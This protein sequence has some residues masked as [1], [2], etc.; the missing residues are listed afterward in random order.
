ML[1]QQYARSPQVSVS[2]DAIDA[3]G[4]CAS[5]QPDVHALGLGLLM[6]HLRS[7]RGELGSAFRPTDA[8]ANLLYFI[9]TQTHPSRKQL[10]F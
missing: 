9:T 1:K 10:L 7:S 2:Q 6:R 8:N 5:T 3:I 4:H